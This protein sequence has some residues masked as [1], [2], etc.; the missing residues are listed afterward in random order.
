M[1]FFLQV[2]ASQLNENPGSESAPL[3]EESPGEAMGRFQSLSDKLNFR[4]R[5][6][7][8]I[9]KSLS[10]ISVDTDRDNAI[11]WLFLA[12]TILRSEAS[13]T[14]KAKSLYDSM[15]LM[16]ATRVMTR[17]VKESL[18]NYKD[19]SLPLSMK[20]ALPVSVAGVSMFG[21]QG[22]GIAGFGTAIGMPVVVVLF[23]GTAGITS[24]L[25]SMIGKG[26][27]SGPQ[28]RLILA[29]IALEGTRRMNNEFLKSLQ[30]DATVPRRSSL[31][32]DYDLLL[33]QLRTMDPFLF[34]RHVM[35]FF[36][37]MEHEVG[38]TPCSND[39]GLD[40]YVLD[41]DGMIVV[42]CKRNAE[43]NKVTRPTVQQFKGVIEE[44]NARIG[45]IVTTSTF[46]RDA[47]ES[48]AKSDKIE[49]VDYERLLAWHSAGAVS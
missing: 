17:V 46:T 1:G 9:S 48:A 19:S 44:Q 10:A 41:P 23:L 29:L 22:V 38:V 40:G 18:S 8:S 45:Y 43:S 47:V 33:Q 49:L 25:E 31:P 15:D 36:E 21:L 27:V 12:R 5:L 6:V 20:V 14:E 11:E 37:S 42:Q 34:E 24:I 39:F 13:K 3:D 28:A 32:E 2:R 4:A 35:S 30:K 16:E 7:S 26:K